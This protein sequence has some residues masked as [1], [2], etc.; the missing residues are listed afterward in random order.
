MH[1]ESLSGR[2]LEASVLSKAAFMLKS[3]QD[4][5][6]APGNDEK[7]TEALKFHQRVWS[8]FQVE[9][10]RPD[11]LLSKE[12]RQDILSLSIFMEK[13]VFEVLAFPARE[14]LNAIININ[15]NLAAGL[16]NKT[17]TEK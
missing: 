2:E 9:L 6:G 4:N 5:W 17:E 1:K 10:A 3:C 16:N 8:I 14:K 11:N 7:L 13:R 15:L 12:L